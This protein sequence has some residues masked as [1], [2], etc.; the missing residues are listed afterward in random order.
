MFEQLR[1]RKPRPVV[2]LPEILPEKVENPRPLKEANNESREVDEM[3]DSRVLPTQSETPR[4]TYLFDEGVW[5]VS[6]VYINEKS[7]PVE[8]EGESTIHHRDGRWLNEINMELKAANSAQYRN[9]QYKSVYEYAPVEAAHQVSAWEASNAAL[10]RLHGTL[11]FIEDMILSSYQTSNGSI[12]GMETMRQI[13]E[14]QY[15]CRGALFER[16]ERTSSW[17]LLYDRT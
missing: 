16:G 4:H 8:V 13:T 14:N 10:G 5:L 17:V 1:A 7:V 3:V 2:A 9:V 11:L 12:R 6:G 15:Q